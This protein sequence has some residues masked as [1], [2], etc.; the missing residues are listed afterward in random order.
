MLSILSYYQAIKPTLKREFNMSNFCGMAWEAYKGAAKGAGMSVITMNFRSTNKQ[1]NKH[2]FNYFECW[3]IDWL[4]LSF[5]FFKYDLQRLKW[6]L[7][8]SILFVGKCFMQISCQS[9]IANNS[10]NSGLPATWRHSR[11][12]EG[13]KEIVVLGQL[14][15]VT[16]N[17]PDNVPFNLS[18]LETA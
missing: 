17:P 15:I 18:R 16:T 2:I 12:M 13:K 3:I 6:K 10:R 4:K 1:T 8:F 9:L 7:F 14:L 11:S 5:Y